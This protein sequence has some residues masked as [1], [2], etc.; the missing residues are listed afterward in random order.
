MVLSIIFWSL[1]SIDFLWLTEDEMLLLDQGGLGANLP[2]SELWYCASLVIWLVL[3][4]GLYFYNKLARVGF[5]LMYA[6]S[7]VLVFFNGVQVLTPLEGAL[8]TLIGLQDGAILAVAYLTGLG[9][10]F[11]QNS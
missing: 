10:K 5:V 4:V 1:P 7:F 2:Y 3:S 6:L 11:E 9:A 8:S